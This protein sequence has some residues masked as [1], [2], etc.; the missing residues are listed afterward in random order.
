MLK[1]GMQEYIMDVK[2]MNATVV[3]C[4]KNTQK[5]LHSWET[6]LPKGSKDIEEAF[7]ST[8]LQEDYQDVLFEC[9]IDDKPLINS[10]GE[11][12]NGDVVQITY[13]SFEEQR[14]E[15]VVA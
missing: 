3:Y 9:F 14:N 1:L 6:V 8:G 11:I 5:V 10:S 13:H 2:G 7:A 15:G 12:K 4:D